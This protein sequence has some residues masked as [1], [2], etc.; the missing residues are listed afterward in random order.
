MR[1]RRSLSLVLILILCFT[2]FT[3]AQSEKT[4]IVINEFKE[5]TDTNI[6]FDRA[7]KGIDESKG[8]LK[9]NSTA[10][11]TN[12]VTNEKIQLQT[13]STTQLLKETKVGNQIVRSYA[14]TAAAYSKTD[15]GNSEG[16]ADVKA[17]STIYWEEYD[18]N[19]VPVANM[20]GAN[21]VTART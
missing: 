4:E 5:I 15:S 7:L 14:T 11:I 9:N 1:I 21:G 10:E 2:T 3:F 16:G 19:N 8:K 20:T 17:T 18:I 12:K 6:L 13:A